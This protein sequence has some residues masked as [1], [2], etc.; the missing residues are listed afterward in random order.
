MK[1]VLLAFV[2]LVFVGCASFSTNEVKS[3]AKS[4]VK[5]EVQEMKKE[6]K[7]EHAKH[8]KH[9]KDQKKAIVEKAAVEVESE[10][11]AKLPCADC[12]GIKS[13]LM[14][15]T[16]GYFVKF[17][18]YEKYIKGKPVLENTFKTR[19]KYMIA[20]GIVVAKGENGEVFK[21]K[22]VGEDLVQISLDGTMPSNPKAYTYKLV[23]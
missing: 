21:F 4:E 14:L 6:M 20:H 23:K 1:K 19:G 17:D 18:E 13:K 2:A 16:N 10:Y 7:H 15:D 5:K 3:E 12:A 8:Q 11:V 22:K 9:M